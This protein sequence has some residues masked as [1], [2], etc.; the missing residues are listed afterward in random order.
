MQLGATCSRL[1][2][3]SRALPV[4]P[5]LRASRV[6]MACALLQRWHLGPWLVMARMSLREAA[7][8]VDTSMSSP[9]LASIHLEERTQCE[10]PLES[11]HTPKD[12]V[13]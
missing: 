8:L 7:G 5:V 9:E 6:M 2:C 4:Q 12:A 10:S 1:P 11:R 13:L 3:M